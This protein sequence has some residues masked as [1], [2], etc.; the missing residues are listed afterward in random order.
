MPAKQ[1]DTSRFNAE[2]IF[3]L[4]YASDPQ[5]SPDGTR[6]VYVRRSHDIMTDQVRSNLWIVDAKGGNHQPIASGTA[7]ASSPRWSPDGQRLAFVSNSDGRGS[8][9]YIRWMDTGAVGLITNL[10]KSP[11]SISWSPDGDEIAFTMSV[12]DERT[13]L[14]VPLP[15]KP[16]GANWAPSFKHIDKARYQADGRGILE[17]AFTHI[18]VVPAEGGSARQ[19]TSGSYNHRGMISWS[20][21]GREILFSANR[22][23]DWE[24]ET[25]E[26]DLYSL[27]VSTGELTALTSEPGGEG[28]PI[29]SP[30]GSRIAYL[31]TDRKSLPYV[32]VELYVMQADGS[33]VQLLTAEIDRHVSNPTWVGNDTLYYQYVDHGVTK[34]GSVDLDSNHRLLVEG[35]DG[36]TLGR[37][38]TSG[39]YSVSSDGSLAFGQGETNRPTDVGSLIK[40]KILKLTALNEDLLGHKTLGEVHEIT[41][42]SSFD[43][44]DIQGWYVTP[45]N[46]DSSKKYPII[47][48]IHGGPY[49]CYGPHFSAEIQRYAE[50]GYVVFY[51]NYRGSKSYGERFALLLDNK[52]SSGEDFADHMSGLDAV[53]ELGFIDPDQQFI[54][55]GSAGGIASAYAIGLTDRFRAAVVAK[56][57]INWISKVLTADSYL[58]QIPQQFPGMPWEHVEAYWKRSPLSLVEN[59]T[60][61]TMLLTGEEDRRTPTSEAVQFYQALKLKRVDTLLVRIPGSSHNIAARP[62]RMIAKVENVLAWFEKYSPSGE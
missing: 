35:I 31:K 17:P 36:E 7:S 54:T 60:T 10:Q 34:I 39:S 3:D 50:A 6:I 38:Y 8:Q 40:G 46:F 25:K 56:P 30:D 29:M 37:P 20:Q 18:F 5:I 48:E 42:A 26:S 49:S 28:Y 41:Y 57:V 19:L 13:I 1:P 12:P 2:D 55:G 16:K 59:V 9:I 44:E 15:K 32:Q 23:D 27:D 51:A 11:S 14:K 47:L 33:D 45:P 58:S 62:S 4:E 21:D 43:G 61:P 53:I 24:Y 52:Y 22:S